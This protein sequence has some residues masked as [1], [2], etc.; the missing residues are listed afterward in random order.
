MEEV[1]GKAIEYDVVDY[2]DS[3]PADEPRRRCPDILKAKI[4]LDYHPKVDINE[5]LKRFINWSDK[6]YKGKL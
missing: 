6:V 4:Q 2:P 3:Y 5:G 1:S